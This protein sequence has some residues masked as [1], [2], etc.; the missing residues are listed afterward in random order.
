MNPKS[1]LIIEDD[2]NMAYLLRYILEREGYAIEH[3]QD[4][5]QAMAYMQE[6]ARADLVLADVMLPYMD[7]YELLKWI[8]EEPQWQLTPVILLTAREQ[9]P[10]VTRAFDMGADDYVK[11]PFSPVE[12]LARI[13]RNIN[14]IHR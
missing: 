12:L 3:R 14:R 11:K 2:P 10:D 13:K 8:R 4:G 9:E 6:H 1:I 5:R 7:G